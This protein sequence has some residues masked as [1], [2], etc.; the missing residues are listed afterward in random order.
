[1]NPSEL[2]T[3]LESRGVRLALCGDEV[4]IR[5]PR[6]VVPQVV[7]QVRTHKAE[8]MK[9]L[10]DRVAVGEALPVQ[11]HTDSVSTAEH[12]RMPLSEFSWS[13]LVLV[14]HATGLDGEELVLAADNAI[15]DPGEQRVVYRASELRHL[16]GLVAAE[17]RSVHKVKGTLRGLVMA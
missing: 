5:G 17:L 10:A 6:S 4:A 7:D 12:L 16:L 8:L 1:M 13:G 15:L 11:L 3:D 2:L 14:V 9:V